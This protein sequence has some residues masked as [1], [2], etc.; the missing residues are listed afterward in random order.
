MKLRTQLQARKR[1]RSLNHS[2]WVVAGDCA[3]LC[4]V[5]LS[6]ALAAPLVE[7]GGV[8]LASDQPRLHRVLRQLAHAQHA[9][10]R[11]ALGDGHECQVRVLL[12][13]RVG[14]LVDELGVEPEVHRR[15]ERA[16]AGLGGGGRALQ[17]RLDAGVDQRGEPLLALVRDLLRD[18][19]DRVAQ[20]RLQ[21]RRDLRRVDLFAQGSELGPD[22]AQGRGRRGLD[23]G[24]EL[25]PAALG[26]LRGG[27]REGDDAANALG[28]RR[29]LGDDEGLRLHGVADV[30]AAAELEAILR[31]L[32]LIWLRLNR[33]NRGSDGDNANRVRVCF[34]EYSP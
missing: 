7:R 1:L 6:A 18:A 26:G 13:D 3:S 28:D 16:P 5:G 29:L 21:R 10:A 9:L 30:R 8:P 24:R 2:L 34:T 32:V 12:A 19:A 23:L 33:A 27:S 4:G 25:R 31:P 11:L 14:H 22:L 15:D 20:R 17:R